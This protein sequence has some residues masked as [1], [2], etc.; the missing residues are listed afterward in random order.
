METTPRF[1][2]VP[3]MLSLSR[4]VLAVIVFVLISTHAYMAALVI[5]V[6]ASSTDWLD[7]YFARRLNQC[8]AIGRQLDPLVDKVIVLGGFIYLLTIEGT[9]LAPWMVTAIVVRELLVQALRSLIEGRGGAFGAV[10]A[11]KLKTALQCLAI[12]AILL[13]LALGLTG[14]WLLVRDVLIW[15]AVILTVYSGIG[16]VRLA[17]PRL[18]GDAP[19]STL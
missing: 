18:R 17:W 8:T 19:A 9:G 6:L 3:N 7:G 13:V 16:Y 12:S 10:M 15:G 2:N 4:L 11:G 1:W 14:P 5:F